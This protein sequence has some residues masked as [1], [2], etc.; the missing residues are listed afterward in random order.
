MLGRITPEVYDRD[1]SLESLI[2]LA[3]FGLPATPPQAGGRPVLRGVVD[4][5]S[6]ED[7]ILLWAGGIYN[8]F[9]PVT[10]IRAA[11]IAAATRPEIR[12]VFFAGKHPN[13]GVPEMRVATQARTTAEKEGLLGRHVFFVDAWIP[14]EERGAYLLEA[15]V[16]L[17]THR[18]HAE[19]TLAFRTR[20]LDYLWAGLPVLCSGG[21]ALGDLA[22]ARG[23]GIAVP[24]ENIQALADRMIAM[25]SDRSQLQRMSSAARLTAKEY[26][27]ERA[28]SPLV[29]FVRDPVPALDRPREITAGGRG[30]PSYGPL[31]WRLSRLGEFQRAHGMRMTIGLIARRLLG[32]R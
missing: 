6:R 17:S 23:F 11:G 22:A 7:F 12:L 28:L 8:W 10:A 5:I 2:A 25:A 26:T 31:R 21:D 32:R 18:N 4:G 20:F 24:S 1:P 29:E 13:P 15:D 16:G 30:R 19:S 3:P 9:D 14:Y 27:W